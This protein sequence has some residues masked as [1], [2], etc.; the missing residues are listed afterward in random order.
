MRRGAPLLLLACCSSPPRA[1]PP[2]VVTIPSVAAPA[3]RPRPA[4]AAA[5]ARPDA[6]RGV[7]KEFWGDAE[8]GDVMYHDVY[9][10]D[11]QP[12]GALRLRVDGEGTIKQPAFAAGELTF[13]QVTAFDV[14]YRLRLK[15]DGRRL[16]GTARS[17]KGTF[18]VRWEKVADRPDDD[19][20]GEGGPDAD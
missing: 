13:T 17:P 16:E 10:L 19:V 20:P 9:R 1:A 3:P 5:G 18:P 11:P 15:P 8:T 2:E 12:G 4:P 14:H 7:W 6:L